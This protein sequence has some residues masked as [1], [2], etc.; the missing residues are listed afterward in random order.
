MVVLEDGR[1]IFSSWGAKSIFEKKADNS[2]ETIAS[3]LESP[4]DIGFDT[5]R[6]RILVPLFMV[7]KV[8][9]L[10]L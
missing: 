2:F 4:A 8:V 7:N 5:K 6:K 3:D 1:V 10:Q 9:I